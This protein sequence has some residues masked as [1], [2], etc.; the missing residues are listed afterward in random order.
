V[1]GSHVISAPVLLADHTAVTVAGPTGSL[2][3]IGPLDASGKNLVKAG[4]GRL[5]ANSIRA[6]SLTISSGTVAIAPAGTASGTSV[7]GDLSIAGD[8]APTAKFDLS[9][10]SAIIDYTG[11]SPVATVRQQIVAGRGGAGIGGNWNGNGITSSSA[12][13]ANATEPESRSVGYA[14]NSALPLGRYT[15]FRGQPVDDTS[16]LIAYTRTGDANLDGVVGD[17]DVTIVGATYAPGVA[18]PHWSLGDF[19]F[20]GFVDDDDVTL[21]GAFYDP[22]ATPLAVETAGA[23]SNLAA[24][25]EPATLILAMV[26]A[27][28]LAICI[29]YSSKPD[30]SR[31]S[32]RDSPT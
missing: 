16:V 7:V 30:A 10:N 28:I 17:D 4:A 14:E 22:S 23:A 18:Q 11:T 6:A 24:V 2:S 21:L 15:T 13:T 27:A 31:A 32:R 20:N 3:I 29:G 5:T 19:D 12:A 26:A 9:N 8:A 25:P 1:T